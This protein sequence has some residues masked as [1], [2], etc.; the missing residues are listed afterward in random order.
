[1]SQHDA[2]FKPQ[3]HQKTDIYL[4]LWLASWVILLLNNYRVIGI[5]DERRDPD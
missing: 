2:D 3:D 4:F 5:Y 1:M